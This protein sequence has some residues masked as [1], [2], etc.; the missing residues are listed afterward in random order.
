MVSDFV[1][2]D[3]ILPELEFLVCIS[4]QM[5]PFLTK[6]QVYDSFPGQGPWACFAWSNEPVYQAQCIA[7]SIICCQNMKV[8]W[9]VDDGFVTSSA[10]QK[11]AVANL[12]DAKK[13]EFYNQSRDMMCA[14][15]GENSETISPQVFNYAWVDISW[16]KYIVAHPNSVSIILLICFIFFVLF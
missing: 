5:L 8:A 3:F 2:D 14:I 13:L 10:L 16:S 4:K 7:R 12:T 1:T 11:I 15:V 6:Y 9:H